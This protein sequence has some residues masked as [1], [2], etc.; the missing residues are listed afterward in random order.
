MH[1]RLAVVVMFTKKTMK[2]SFGKLHYKP[3]ILTTSDAIALGQIIFL[4]INQQSTDNE[5][6]VSSQQNPTKKSVCC[7]WLYSRD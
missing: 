4:A 7:F 1:V 2:L 3:N 6:K 5:K